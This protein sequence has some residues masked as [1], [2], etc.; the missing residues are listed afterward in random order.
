[1]APPVTPVA[2]PVSPTA[3]V[4]STPGCEAYVGSSAD[5]ANCSN[6]VNNFGG[7]YDGGTCFT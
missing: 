7:Y 5:C 2:P 6:C 3:N 1:V 4:C